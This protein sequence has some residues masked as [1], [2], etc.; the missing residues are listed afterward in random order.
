[1]KSPTA[2]IACLIINTTNPDASAR[3]WGALLDREVG[4]QYSAYNELPGNTGDIK[5]TIQKV[6]Q[7]SGGS[8]I[9]FDLKVN[10]FEEAIR[11]IEAL[12]GKL[13]KRESQNRWYW[14]VLA[15][16]DGNLFCIL[17]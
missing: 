15:D 5:L 8:S 2:K 10:D 6:E 1:M 14:A 3:F 9:H 16:P 12:G 7:W 17:P 4:K 13:V 11:K